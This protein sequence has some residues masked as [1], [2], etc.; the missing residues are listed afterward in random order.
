MKRSVPIGRYHL[1]DR[2]GSGGM[3]EVYRAKY[4]DDEGSERLVALKRVL[5]MYA[6]DPSFVQMLV[7][8]YRLS[9]LLVHPNI[10]QIHE[11]LRTPDGYFIVMELVDGKDLRSVL[12]RTIDAKR[13]FDIADA[14]YLMARAV[15]GLHHAHTATLPDGTPLELVH[16]DFSPSNIL[17]GYDGSVKIIDFGI[18]KANVQRDRTAV[19]VIKGKVRY[20]SPE[21]ANGDAR[22]NGQ[23]DVFSAGSVLYELL[24]GHPA[25]AAPTEL[26]LIYT[27]RRAE[28]VPL[29]ELAPH[30]PPALVEVVR[31]AMARDRA[32]RYPDAAAFREALVGFLRNFAPGYRRTRLANHMKTAFVHEIEDE[33]NTLLEYALSDLPAVSAENLLEAA[34]FEESLQEVR[35]HSTPS[36]LGVRPDDLF[37]QH[38]Y[39]LFDP[40]PDEQPSSHEGPEISFDPDEQTENSRSPIEPDQPTEPT[41]PRPRFPRRRLIRS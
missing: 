15:D 20:M 12:Q 14:V 32:D 9:M 2:M 35:S 40:L 29:L 24:C 10:A 13:H 7:A 1:L 31:C 33:I 6:D 3:A 5:S 37:A 11:L 26:E 36:L 39:A 17:V 22:L 28:P 30:L 38:F 18:A 8:E 4:V 23:S 19:G 25:F 27:V 34:E 16:R 21:Q 41:R